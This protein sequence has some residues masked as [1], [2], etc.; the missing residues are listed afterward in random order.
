MPSRSIF[1]ILPV[2]FMP[3]R[4]TALALALP[5]REAGTPPSRWLYFALRAEILEGRLRPGAR[6]PATRDLGR[7]YGLSRGTVVSA[8]EQLKSEGYLKGVVGS[9]TYVSHTLPDDLLQVTRKAGAQSPLRRSQVRR[10]SDFGRRVTL[11]PGFTSRP[12]RAF[13]CHQ[14][15][16]DLFPT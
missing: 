15:A 5:P 9:G 8:F 16:L 7:E 11:F 6:L 1:G 14:P 3:K 12:T 2:P 13:R 4:T 10:V